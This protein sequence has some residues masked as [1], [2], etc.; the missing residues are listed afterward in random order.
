[1]KKYFYMVMAALT[2]SVGMTSCIDEEGPGTPSLPKMHLQSQEYN[3]DLNDAQAKDL[4][5]RW[6]DVKNAVYQVVLSNNMNYAK[7]TLDYEQVKGDLST[8]SMVID[9][10]TIMNYVQKAELYWETADKKDA[11]GNLLS[12]EKTV[13]INIDVTGTPTVETGTA[14]SKEGSTTSAVVNIKKVLYAMKME[15]ENTVL[16]ID[17]EAAAPLMLSWVDVNNT[18][19]EISFSAKGVEPII[20]ELPIDV[21]DGKCSTM[22]TNEIIQEYITKL[23]LSWKT[24]NGEEGDQKIRY[25]SVTFQINVKGTPK[26]LGDLETILDAEGN[27][28]SIEMDVR[29]EKELR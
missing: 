2:L 14:L 13:Q 6:I 8:L 15:T 1:M 17:D 18:D 28:V 12:K 24:R 27:T 22:I 16:Y 21:V 9:Y 23:G 5:L 26:V 7:D 3:I 29:K 4:T 20:A 19:Y 25:K 10:E 11:K